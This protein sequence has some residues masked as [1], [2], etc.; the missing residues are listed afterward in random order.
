MAAMMKEQAVGDEQDKYLEERNAAFNQSF[1]SL[2]T[3]GTVDYWQR[4]EPMT[5]ENALP[6]EVLG[7]CIRERLHADFKEDA[8]RL[9]TALWLR[10]QSDV[11]FWA[12]RIASQYRDGKKLDIAPDLEQKCSIAL[13]QE[14]FEDGPTFL[15]EHFGYALNYIQKHVAQAVLEKEGLRQRRGVKRP[16]RPPR[17]EIESIE[18]QGDSEDD[19]P[20]TVTLADPNAQTAIEQIAFFLDLR[21]LLER[22]KPEQRVVIYA[23]FV[24][25]LTPQEIAR[26]LQITDR[27]VLYRIEKALEQLGRW[28]SEGEEEHRG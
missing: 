23:R 19:L 13:W 17:Q 21:A 6:L 28:Y 4:I 15:L 24:Q 20:L 9:F 25:G 5:Q 22:L 3:P 7:R 2:P 26:E 14:L 8:K 16:T 12:Q 27:A 11:Q 1:Q 10:I 18:A